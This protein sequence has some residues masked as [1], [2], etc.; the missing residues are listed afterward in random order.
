MMNK[1]YSE[2]IRLP[3]FIQRYR[4]LKLGGIIGEETFG[5]DR[6]L[7]QILYRSPE[8]KRFR[9]DIIIRDEARDLACEGY[10]IVGKILIHH[11]NPITVRDIELRDSK[12]F[13][14]ENVISV[15]LNT[16]N[17]IHYGD[18]SLLIT[19]PLERTLYD[20]CPWK[21]T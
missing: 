14:P 13:D 4:Y 2:L 10:D 12:I 6:Y 7:N 1:C 11:M 3:T 21:R 8:W 9:R 20:T 17:A 15:T 16:H 19:E 18:E 5:H